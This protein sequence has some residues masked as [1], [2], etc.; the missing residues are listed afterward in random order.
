MPALEQ[1]PHQQPQNESAGDAAISSD[2]A[3]RSTLP[4]RPKGQPTNLSLL[5]ELMCEEPLV[6]STGAEERGESADGSGDVDLHGDPEQRSPRNPLRRQPTATI[7][8]STS[9]RTPSTNA[10]S[11]M[12]KRTCGMDHCENIVR[13]RGLC[14]THGGGKRCSVP[15][16]NTCSVGGNFCI[17]HGGGKKCQVAGCGSVVQSRGFCKAHGGGARCLVAG[18]TKSSQGGGKC[19]SHGGGKRCSIAGCMKG[20]QRRGTC[21]AHADG[22]DGSSHVSASANTTTDESN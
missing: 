5:A 9:T 17:R 18:C 13:S 4:R 14:K 3:A 6:P 7:S 16:C 2:T 22:K 8:T 10:K 21:H 20:A 15:G 1:Q 11:H 12:S 19:T